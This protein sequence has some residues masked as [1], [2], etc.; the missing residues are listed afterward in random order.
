MSKAMPVTKLQRELRKTFGRT[1]IAA[2]KTQPAPQRVDSKPGKR[3]TGTTVTRDSVKA[4]SRDP[5]SAAKRTRAEARSRAGASASERQ[6]GIAGPRVSG[7]A[8]RKLTCPIDAAL[9]KQLKRISIEEERPL[10]EIVETVLRSY[11]AES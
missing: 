1:A 7:N 4:H 3:Q 6:S 10:R 9:Y 8:R 11:V 2:A 5:V